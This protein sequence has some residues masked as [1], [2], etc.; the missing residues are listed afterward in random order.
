M[1]W[2]MLRADHVVRAGVA[3]RGVVEGGEPVADAG[4]GRER[5]EPDGAARHRRRRSVRLARPRAW[6]TRSSGCGRSATVSAPTIAQSPVARARRRLLRVAD[7][8]RVTRNGRRPA[9]CC[10]VTVVGSVRAARQR[11]GEPQVQHRAHALL[12]LPAVVLRRLLVA[13]AQAREHDLVGG[14][15]R[16]LLGPHQLAAVVDEVDRLRAPERVEQR[17]R[18]PRRQVGVGE[19]RRHVDALELALQQERHGRDPDAMGE[20]PR[21]VRIRD[22][23]QVRLDLDELF[24]EV[25]RGR[26]HTGE[27]RLG[28]A[29]R[30]VEHVES[31]DVHQVRELRRP[32]QRRVEGVDARAEERAGA[33]TRR[34]GRGPGL[35]DDPAGREPLIGEGGEDV[36]QP[37][38][39]AEQPGGRERR[40]VQGRAAAHGGHEAQRQERVGPSQR[41]RHR[42]AEVHVGAATAG[43]DAE[44]DRPVVDVD[45][46]E[47]DRRGHRGTLAAGHPRRRSAA[48]THVT[49][50]A[51]MSS[52][53][54]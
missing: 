11:A 7:P 16:H 35:G 47:L 24:A 10:T 39:V 15:P 14:D 31:R 40:E 42:G 6:R 44:R 48:V 50:P 8:L 22:R 43:H 33:P 30:G 12:A 37:A 27:R 17:V 54:P 52:G 1:P 49:N 51:A 21:L 38:A 19:A 18:A 3:H 45:V 29:R 46:D 20:V 28:P 32:L 4:E 25:G 9:T 26:P 34:R 13:D 2:A 53:R 36:L 23:P 41:Q 5:G